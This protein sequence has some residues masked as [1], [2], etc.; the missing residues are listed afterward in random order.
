MHDIEPFYHWR[1]KYISAEDNR[2]PFFGRVY[3]EFEFSQKVYNYYI[4]PQW[5]HFGSNTLYTKILFA[6]YEAGF[7]ILEMLGEWNDCLQNDVMFLK[8][9]VIDPMLQEGINRF[10]LVCENVLNF[11]GSDD[12]YYEEW[13][14]DIIE[15]DG[16]IT[17]LNLLNH[18]EDEM[19]ETQL[20]HFV[21][22]GDYFNQLNWRTQ[23]PKHLH[24]IVDALVKGATPT[25]PY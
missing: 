9:E 6:D 13:F 22:F 16:W 5:D 8:R 3:S 25:L 2:S 11:H 12:S 14:E 10:V 7:A 18:V 4:H 17:F 20:Q 24:T 1:D 19:K 23:K 15:E 21:N